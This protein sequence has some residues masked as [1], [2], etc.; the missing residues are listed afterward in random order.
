MQ[1]PSLLSLAKYHRRTDD[2]EEI[3]SVMRDT[4]RFSRV[5]ND[6]ALRL[7]KSMTAAINSWHN[8]TYLDETAHSFHDSGESVCHE[9]GSNNCTEFHKQGLENGH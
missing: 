8:G 1:M 6:N 3:Q 2:A 4:W 9:A 5:E 7:K